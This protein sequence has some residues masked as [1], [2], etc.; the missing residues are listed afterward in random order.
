MK[1]GNENKKRDPGLH[2]LLTRGVETLID[3]EGVFEQKLSRQPDKLVIKL[4]ADPSSS[5]LH[6]GHAVILRKLRQFQDHGARV[7]FILGDFTARIGDPTGKDK[8]RPELS[9][10]EIEKNLESYRNQIGKIIRTDPAVF[11]AIRNSDWYTNVTDMQAPAGTIVKVAVENNGIKTEIPFDAN[12]FIGKAILY[13]QSRMQV[14]DMKHKTGIVAITIRTFF[15]TLRRITH[16][17][18]IDRDMF[19]ERLSKGGE[20]YLHEMLYPVM[21]AIDSAALGFIFGSC[22]LEIGGTDQTF[23]MLIGR[24]VMSGNNQTPQAV[25]SMRILTGLDG[26][27]K[28]SK[29]LDNCISINDGPDEMYGKTMSIPDTL[30]P[31]YFELATYVPASVLEQITRDLSSGKLHPKDAKMRLGKEIVAIYHGE[32]AAKFAQENFINTFSRKEIP[33]DLKEIKA[34]KGD[35]LGKVLKEAGLVPSLSQFKRLV[36]E[37]AVENLET[38]KKITDPNLKIENRLKLR[39]GKKDFFSIIVF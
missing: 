20:L 38:G 28:M 26:K 15:E 22:D 29:S 8:T 7:V 18:L 14:K 31:E 34:K 11:T 16:Q 19:T 35:L 4:G 12:S 25:M 23:N 3:P 13:E 21:Q 37:G 30:I 5:D 17:R 33:S 6:L 2:D 39:V 36:T 24:D 1:T 27:E 9:T 10:K 32:K